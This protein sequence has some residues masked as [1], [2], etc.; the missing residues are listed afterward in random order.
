MTLPLDNKVED[1]KS[2]KIETKTRK[3][4]ETKGYSLTI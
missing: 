2:Y 4:L 1:N 3:T